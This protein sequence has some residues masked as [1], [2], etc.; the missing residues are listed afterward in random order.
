MIQGLSSRKV[1][2]KID[3]KE[4]S[5]T[6]SV[7]GMLLF[8]PEDLFWKVLRKSTFNDDLPL[9]CGR[10]LSYKF[11][12]KWNSENTVNKKYVEPDIFI[13]FENFDVVI[14]AKRWDHNQ[15][16]RKQWLDQYQSYKNEYQ[17]I[18][19]EVNVSKKLLYFAVGG[20]RN[21]NKELLKDDVFV[22]KF[23]WEKILN[24]LMELEKVL[25]NSR[26]FLITSEPIIRIIE[27]LKIAFELHGFFT[28]LW[29]E[30][31]NKTQFKKNDSL[32]K[33]NKWRI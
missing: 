14:E 7:F 19:E 5:L 28:G 24:A 29:L 32:K 25:L 20:I 30:S 22:Y 10:I 4:D 17:P 8:L 3:V 11:W 18:D 33:I 16:Y 12:P 9:N 26:D 6:S 27:S 1:K 23:R 21:K 31:L 15:Q 13:E 2:I